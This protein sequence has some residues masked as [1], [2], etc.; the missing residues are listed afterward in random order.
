MKQLNDALNFIDSIQI[1][2][3]TLELELIKSNGHILAEDIHSD[4]NMPPFDKSAMDGYACRKADL[5]MPLD[6][7]EFIG[8][9]T[10][11]T[12]IIT[13]G[14]CSKIMTGAKLPEGADCVIM[15]EYTSINEDGKV[16]FQKENTKENICYLGEDV[17]KGDQVL[18]K[19]TKISPAVIAVAASVGKTKLLT[20]KPPVIAL[21]ATGDE[22]IEP[23]KVPEGPYIRNSNSYNIQT[24]ILSTN[25]KVNYLGIIGDDKHKLE[26]AISAALEK[27]DILI[28]TGGVSMGDK[29]YVPDILKDKGLH[30]EF[31]KMAIQPGKPVALAHGNGKYCFALSGNP[32][33]SMLQFE[34]LVR[35]FIYHFMGFS[36]KLP[37][38]KS[39]IN[40]SK[41]RKKSERMQFFPVKLI[42]GEL[43]V[44][45]FHGSAHISGMVN[46]NGLAIF[47]I[48]KETL[49][50]GS[51]VDVLLIN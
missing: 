29:D 26:K 8:A 43:E 12:K 31:N 36:Y 11:P 13:K 30:I 37:I 41:T 20:Y 14:N 47:P 1:C 49:E 9:G 39:Q 51:E 3:N 4:I 27:S 50:K 35:P 46:A 45:E 10:L 17:R 32:V 23:E 48:G 34:L 21:I 33:S 44:L 24:Q 5:Y 16:I 7:L 25:A 18:E 40:I 2:R 22:L 28:L 6:V 19:G 38:V 42:N 15:V